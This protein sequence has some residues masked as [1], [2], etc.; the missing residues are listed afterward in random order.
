MTAAH[1]LYLLVFIAWIYASAGCWLLQVTC[2]PTYGLVGRNEFVPF[3][4]EFGKRLIPVF[5][6]PAV[7]ANLGSVLL[8]FLRPATVP[9]FD[10]IVAAACS[11]VILATTMLIEVPKHVALDRDGKSEAV[12]IELVRS[13]L[14]RVIGWTVGAAALAHGLMYAFRP[15]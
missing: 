4:I 2:Y 5:V 8:C 7:L 15:A 11:V 13:N 1:A 10:V 6:V 12:L 14:P 9:L 3:H